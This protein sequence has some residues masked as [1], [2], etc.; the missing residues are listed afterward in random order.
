MCVAKGS[1]IVTDK[2]FEVAEANVLIAKGCGIVPL[3]PIGHL[4]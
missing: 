4:P 3:R 2:S 1:F